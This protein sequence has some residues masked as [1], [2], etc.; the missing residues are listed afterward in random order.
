M[1][2]VTLPNRVEGEGQGLVLNGM[3]LRKKAIFKV[4][5]AGLSLA[6]HH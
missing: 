5:V 2:D 3:A 4:Y 1:N 6:R